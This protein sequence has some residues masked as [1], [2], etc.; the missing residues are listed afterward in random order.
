MLDFAAMTTY[1]TNQFRLSAVTA[2]ATRDVPTL[3]FRMVLSA[4]ETLTKEP[5][6]L[7]SAPRVATL[8]G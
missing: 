1:E 2:E 8:H 7:A 3:R 4:C 5:V 6:R